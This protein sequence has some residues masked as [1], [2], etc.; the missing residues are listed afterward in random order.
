MLSLLLFVELKTV[1]HKKTRAEHG[2]FE[3]LLAYQLQPTRAHRDA[4]SSSRS[5]KM[6][7]LMAF[8]TDTVLMYLINICLLVTL[9]VR[10]VKG[11]LQ[12]LLN[13]FQPRYLAGCTIIQH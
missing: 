3:N 1:G 2:F 8:P 12:L 10:G 7:E 11:E 4:H 5:S 9:I 13:C 6:V